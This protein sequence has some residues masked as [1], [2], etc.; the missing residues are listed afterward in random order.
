ME[1]EIAGL[2]APAL[3]RII[4][5][6]TSAAVA[7]RLLPGVEVS[8]YQGQDGDWHS[9]VLLDPRIYPNYDLLPK[10]GNRPLTSSNDRR[11]WYDLSAGVTVYTEPKDSP[12]RT[13]TREDALAD[14]RD[15]VAE[16][17]TEIA[18]IGLHSAVGS[19]VESLEPRRHHKFPNG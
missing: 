10:R 1:K 15:M 5:D 6:V 9:H 8:I 18:L 3:A 14:L 19:Y 12:L 16:L 13:R 17:L 2:V 11:W 4:E 7:Q